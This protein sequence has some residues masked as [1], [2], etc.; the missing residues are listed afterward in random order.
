M[1]THILS[2]S[3]S[4]SL[5]LSVSLSLY[6]FVLGRVGLTQVFFKIYP[7][8]KTILTNYKIMVPT[9]YYF[10]YFIFEQITLEIRSE[11]EDAVMLART[12]FITQHIMSTLYADENTHQYILGVRLWACG[13]H[14][15]LLIMYLTNASLKL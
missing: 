5:S 14:K 10:L 12:R 9:K 8:D 7:T 1:Y 13:F 11:A 15:Y 4:I 3:L 6:I 2:L